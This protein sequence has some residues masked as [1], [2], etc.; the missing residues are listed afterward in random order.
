MGFVLGELCWRSAVLSSREGGDGE[1]DAGQS[2]EVLQRQRSDS[3]E[4]RPLRL[5]FLPTGG[6][7]ALGWR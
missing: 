3:G 5:P 7:S 4:S 2:A 1:W 6:H